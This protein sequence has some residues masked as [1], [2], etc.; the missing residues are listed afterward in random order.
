M[1]AVWADSFVEDANLT[2]AISHLRKA[3]GQNGDT[4]EYIETVPRVGYRFVADV[5]EV[6]EKPAPLVVEKH[7]LSRTVIEEELIHDEP[8][9]EVKTQAIVVQP[10]IA[11]RLPVFVRRHVTALFLAAMALSALTLGAVLFFR[12][13]RKATP[14]LAA[15]RSISSIAVLPPRDLSGKADEAPLS[16]GVADALITRLGGL[17]RVVVRPTS[18]IVRYVDSKQDSVNAGRALGVDAVLEGTLQR[19]GDRVRVTLRLLKVAN[20]AQLWAGSFDEASSD[21]FK[22]QD[23]IARQVGE[24]LFTDLS[25]DEKA[26][27]VKQQSTNPEA[28]ALYLKGNYYWKRRGDEVGK[29]FEYFRKAIE[30]DPS[31]TEAYV[32]LGA[33]DSVSFLPSPEADALIDKAL[34]LDNSSAEAHATYGFIRMFHHYEWATA[35]RE[36][37]RAIE[38]NPNSVTAH[39]WKGVYWSLR[40]RLDEAKAEM[41]RAL[42]LDLQ[43]LI[44]TAD[45]G[46][47]HYF[48]HEYDQAIEYCKRTLAMD[49]SFIFAHDYLRDIYQMKGM[50]QEFF[51]EF[52][53][54]SSPADRIK[55]QHVL[56][57]AGRKGLLSIELHDPNHMSQ[58]WYMEWLSASLGDK[59]KA[60]EYLNRAFQ[61]RGIGAF[62]LP[63]INVDPLFDFLRDDPRFEEIVQ[64]MGL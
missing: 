60:L 2:V 10:A 25:P 17:R 23:S 30:L 56:A 51:E 43:S 6:R 20:G 8:H 19:E 40:G 9:A 54:T 15:I 7:T 16:L 28:Y 38:L 18:A 57:G 59:E 39:H 53:R 4:A 31:F 21:I 44:I 46:Q 45:I 27:L 11:R 35:E 55:A 62:L 41:P 26:L 64:R 49:N 3:L 1:Q 32:E 63:F 36:L 61:E 14:D 37:D 22:L 29:S 24:T 12:S 42:E 50:D 52:M 47:L 13:E 5:R 34:Q 58:T 48:A 33:A